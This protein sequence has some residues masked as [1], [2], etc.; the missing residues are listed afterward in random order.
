MYLHYVPCFKAYKGI[1][2]LVSAS[3]V[4]P[5]SAQ[6]NMVVTGREW[7]VVVPVNRCGYGVA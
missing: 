6:R 3:P 7:V 2:D 5:E 4:F 1:T